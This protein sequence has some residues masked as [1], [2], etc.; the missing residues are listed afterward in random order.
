LFD[1]SQVSDIFFFATKTRSDW[2]QPAAQ[3][4]QQREESSDS[5]S[6]FEPL[7]GKEH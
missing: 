3:D 2:R 1:G 6:L 7:C 4:R 5:S